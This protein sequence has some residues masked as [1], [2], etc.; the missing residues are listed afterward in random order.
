M[1]IMDG[2]LVSLNNM[3]S[4]VFNGKFI[5]TIKRTTTAIK[6]RWIKIRDTP[7]REEKPSI[8]GK[9]NRLYV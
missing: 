4:D 3:K 1:T 8:S 7:I 9:S 2:N 6:I 5:I